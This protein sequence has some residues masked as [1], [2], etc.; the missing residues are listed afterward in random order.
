M[1]ERPAAVELPFE[2]AASEAV[3]ARLAVAGLQAA[4]DRREPVPDRGIRRK[5]SFDRAIH[6]LEVRILGVALAGQRDPPVDRFAVHRTPDVAE[7][8]TPVDGLRANFGT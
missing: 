2:F 7:V 3:A 4:I 8:E 5:R 6:R 1:N